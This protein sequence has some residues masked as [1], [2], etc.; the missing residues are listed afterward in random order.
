MIAGV[1]CAPV[2]RKERFWR[3]A[4]SKEDKITKSSPAKRYHQL[5]VEKTTITSDREMFE[6]TSQMA[7]TEKA[8]DAGH[9]LWRGIIGFQAAGD[10][11]G[12]LKM[13]REL[14]QAIPDEAD[15]MIKKANQGIP[16]FFIDRHL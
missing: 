12:F 13:G 8:M 14:A 1:K 3:K 9:E 16:E 4:E 10:V 2:L 6:N 5:A 11:N 15:A 7:A